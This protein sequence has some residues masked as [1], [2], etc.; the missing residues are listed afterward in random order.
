MRWPLI[1]CILLTPMGCDGTAESP[2]APVQDIDDAETTS[3]PAD[4]DASD[5]QETSSEEE[6]VDPWKRVRD[7]LGFADIGAFSFT[8]GTAEGVAFTHHKGGSTAT[9]PYA[10]ASSSYVLTAKRL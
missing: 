9:T 4:E 1:F 2:S 10:R 5:T 8:V 3:I 7:R 6:P